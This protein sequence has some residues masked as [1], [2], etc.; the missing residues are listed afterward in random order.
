[1]TVKDWDDF[2]GMLMAER[3]MSLREEFK[4]A[5]K[6]KAYLKYFFLAYDVPRDNLALEF[7]RYL[8]V[9][10]EVMRDALIS[11]VRESSEK[12]GWTRDKYQ[13]DY[14][15]EVSNARCQMHFAIRWLWVCTDAETK[16]LLW[17]IAMDSAKDRVYRR[18]ATEAYLRRADVDVQETK[19][20]F[21]SLFEDEARLP[22]DHITVFKHG[23]ETVLKEKMDE[24]KREEIDAAY[25]VITARE[26][27]E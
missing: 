27:K 8:P 5:E 1:M 17:D 13:Q 14:S 22:A 25:R 6:L 18:A 7:K 10:D 23:I 4:D 15:G 19:D 11:L 21:K 12:V 26:K 16:K 2:Q 24:T 20:F 3:I 9:S